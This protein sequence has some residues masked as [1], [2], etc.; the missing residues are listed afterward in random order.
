MPEKSIEIRTYNVGE[1]KRV[2]SISSEVWAC[3]GPKYLNA[4]GNL[5]T[6]VAVFQP[7]S[8]AELEDIAKS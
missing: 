8:V 5:D 6:V 7:Y 3:A 4:N 2:S 1:S